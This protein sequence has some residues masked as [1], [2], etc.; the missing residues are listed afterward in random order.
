[1]VQE[2]LQEQF[3][4]EHLYFSYTHLVCRTAKDGIYVCQMCKGLFTQCCCTRTHVGLQ[5]D[6][7]DLSHPVHADNCILDHEK[8]ECNKAAPAYTWRD[9]RYKHIR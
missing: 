5:D 6:R 2:I 3:K 7:Q 1:M 8:G 4:L 9:Y